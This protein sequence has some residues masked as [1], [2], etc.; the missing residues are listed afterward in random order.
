[1]TLY[2]IGPTLSIS[3]EIDSASDSWRRSIHPY[4]APDSWVEE[5][6]E[7]SNQTELLERHSGDKKVEEDAWTGSWEA[8][9]SSPQASTSWLFGNGRSTCLF[10]RQRPRRSFGG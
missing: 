8:I 5:D 3:V 10:E 9:D 4:A 7:M 2:C 6:I 1:V